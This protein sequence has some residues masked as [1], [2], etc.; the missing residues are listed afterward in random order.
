MNIDICFVHFKN[1]ELSHLDAAWY[2]LSKQ[3]FTGVNCIRFVDNDTIHTEEQIR[4]VWNRYP[5]PVPILPLFAKHGNSGWTHSWST[6]RVCAAVE[7][8]TWIFYTRTDYIL[9]FDCLSRFREVANGD[10]VL[11]TSWVWMMGYDYKMENTYDVVDIERYNWRERGMAALLEHPYVFKFQ[12][13][14]KDAGVWLTRRDWMVQAGGLNESLASWGFQQ[15]EF[16]RGLRRIGVEMRM[17][18]EYLYAH[19][20]HGAPRDFHKAQAEFN[21]HGRW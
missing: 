18:P 14:D 17:I 9:A 8:E 16:Q 10:K 5:V 19:Q 4:E 6:N 13:A 2:S 12:D 21:A 15:S 7:A 20:H 11:V 1:T 3:D